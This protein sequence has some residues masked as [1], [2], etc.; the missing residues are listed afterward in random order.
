MIEKIQILLSLL[1]RPRNLRTLL[2]LRHRGYLVDIGW[3]Q[4]AEKKMP[5]N[6]NGQPIPWYSYPFLSFIED[7]LKKNISQEGCK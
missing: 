1:F 4:S 3:F 7:R 5:V 2:S 6:K